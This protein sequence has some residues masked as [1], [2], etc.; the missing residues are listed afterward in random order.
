MIKGIHHVSVTTRKFDVLVKFYQDAFGFMPAAEEGRWENS[1]LFDNVIGQR[2]TIARQMLLKAGNCYLEVFEYT[3]PRGRE[4]G[5][6]DPMDSGYTHFSVESTDIEADYRRLAALGME[7]VY[8]T[9][10]DFG[11]AKAVYGKDP[12]GRIIEISQLSP[13]LPFSLEQL[14]AGQAR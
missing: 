12:E 5:P 6:L 1:T 13:D 14:T 8:P 10:V 7:F 9:P 2:G 3:A 4:L 11:A